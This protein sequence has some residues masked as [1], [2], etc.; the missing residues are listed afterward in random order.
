MAHAKKMFI[1][2]VGK[3]LIFFDK[4][5]K[6]LGKNYDSQFELG[7]IYMNALYFTKL[8]ICNKYKSMFRTMTL[9][10]FCET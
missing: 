4:V 8:T 1:C 10:A 6:K 2:I 9:V 5:T 7:A 3:T